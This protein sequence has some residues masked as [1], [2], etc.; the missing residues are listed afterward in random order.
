MKTQLFPDF[1]PL[2]TYAE[3]VKS[4]TAIRLGIT[5]VPTAEQY[6]NMVQAYKDFYV[7]ICKQF[8]KL[9]VSSFFRSPALNRAVKG[10]GTSA[11]MAGCAIDIDC[12]GLKTPTNKE[13]YQWCRAN[14]KFDQCITEFP[15]ANGNPGWIHIAH[16]RTGGVDRQQGMRAVMKQGSVY[17]IYE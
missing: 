14:L 4:T 6:R 3:S 2:L 17:Y 13:L 7:T 16:N 10:S 15:D 12:D 1:G 5:N 11:H 8:G 9:P